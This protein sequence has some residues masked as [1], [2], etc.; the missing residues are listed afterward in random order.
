MLPLSFLAGSA[1]PLELLVIFIFVLILF[2]PRRLPEI[3]RSLG[4][5]L[6]ALRKAS[7]DFKSQV[8]AIEGSV[9]K[10]VDNADGRQEGNRDDGAFG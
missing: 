7:D 10:P 6:H 2:G 3:A 1:G 4:R 5:A 9:T 8:M